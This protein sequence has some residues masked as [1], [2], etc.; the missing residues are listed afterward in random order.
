M[1]VLLFLA[2]KL[3]ILSHSPLAERIEVL[4]RA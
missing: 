1:R 2:T 4:R 3:G